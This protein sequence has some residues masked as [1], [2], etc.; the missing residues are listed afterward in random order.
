MTTSTRERERERDEVHRCISVDTSNPSSEHA[1]T[2]NRTTAVDRGSNP[3]T[4][5]TSAP[6]KQEQERRER[7]RNRGNR[8]FGRGRGRGRGGPAYRRW[9]EGRLYNATQGDVSEDNSGSEADEAQPPPEVL[10]VRDGLIVPSNSRGNRR[11]GGG[12]GGGYGGGF[13][14]GFG[15][16][17]YYSSESE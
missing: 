14:G 12:R 15:G 7:R 6:L 1:H 16:G 4:R 13:G 8:G 5:P 2:H 17:G 9:D 11:R 3:F 10:F